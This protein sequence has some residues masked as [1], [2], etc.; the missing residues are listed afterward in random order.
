MEELDPLIVSRLMST[1]PVIIVLRCN[2]PPIQCSTI[3]CSAMQF[4][5]R[6]PWDVRSD[7]RRL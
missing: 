7:S 5:N 4:W 3:Q 1:A 2:V 6:E